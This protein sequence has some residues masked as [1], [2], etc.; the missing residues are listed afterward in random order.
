M[1]IPFKRSLTNSIFPECPICHSIVYWK[2]IHI[3]LNQDKI[4]GKNQY[5]AITIANY[6]ITILFIFIFG[7]VVEWC[8]ICQMPHSSAAWVKLL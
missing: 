6:S 1:H 5:A 2:N 4:E 3:S 7:E 8:Y